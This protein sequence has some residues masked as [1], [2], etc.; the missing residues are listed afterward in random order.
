MSLACVSAILIWAL[1]FVGSATRGE[2]GAD[3]H[4]LAN[5][6][7]QGLE[8]ADH[9]GPDLE[10]VHLRLLEH[11]GGK[12]AVHV[13]LLRGELGLERL[14]GV[15]EALLVEPEAGLEVGGLYA[16]KLEI[17]RGNEAVLGELFVHLELELRLAEVGAELGVL[18]AAVEDALLQGGAEGGELGFAGPRVELGI[19]SLLLQL[20]I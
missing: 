20:G 1:S 12:E 3:R 5:L 19:G 13:G 9:A 8:H 11:G 16:G 10:G 2:V 4:A 15:F 7:G 14:L 18:G 6:E 17:E